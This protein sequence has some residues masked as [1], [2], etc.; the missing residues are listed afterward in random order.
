ME[1]LFAFLGLIVVMVVV[2]LLN[3]Y[4][5][6][7]HRLTRPPRHLGEPQSQRGRV[8]KDP[9]PTNHNADPYSGSP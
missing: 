4:W 8:Y 3:A 5:Q 9:P 7:K 1:Y 6:R 2:Y